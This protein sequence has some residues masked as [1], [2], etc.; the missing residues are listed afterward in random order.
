MIELQY[1]IK[2]VKKK[3]GFDIFGFGNIIRQRNPKLWKV[4]ENDWDSIFMDIDFNIVCDIEIRNSGYSL[5]PIKVV[6]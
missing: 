3:F 4:I 2:Y 1:Q 5:K 6:N